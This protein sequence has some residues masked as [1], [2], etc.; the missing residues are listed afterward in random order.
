ML[1][2]QAAAG[3]S[4]SASVTTKNA[5]VSL[6]AGTGT[7]YI[8]DSKSLST[9]SQSLV[10]TADDIAILNS[11]TLNLGVPVPSCYACMTVHE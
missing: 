3:I 8:A 10:I 7:L 6:A 1:C 9:S 11:G 2:S 4:F 5:A